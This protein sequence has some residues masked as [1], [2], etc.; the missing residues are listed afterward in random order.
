MKFALVVIGTSLGGLNALRAIISTL[1][2]SFRLPIVI[3]QHRGT[4]MN[5]MF[6]S[7]MQK[8]SHHPMMIAAD[9][10]PILPAHIYLA[11]SGYHLMI[12]NDHFVLSTEEPVNYAMP[13]IDLLF[14]TAADSFGSRTIGVILTGT[15]KDGAEG[16]M[17]IER[18]GGVA[19]I[20]LPKTAF[21]Q[22]MPEAAIDATSNAVKLNLNEI[23][24]YLVKLDQGTG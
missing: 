3:V 15:G 21:A 23:G 6:Q 22:E 4:D 13:S 8:V 16:L 12:E 18:H 17:K 10:T 1:P 9:K 5:E 14:E 24:P 11:P 20:E 7:L 2:D 19:I